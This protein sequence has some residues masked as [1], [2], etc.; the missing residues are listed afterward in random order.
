MTSLTSYKPR[1]SRH[2]ETPRIVIAPTP[3]TQAIYNQIREDEA[4]HS[5]QHSLHPQDDPADLLRPRDRRA[6]S[7]SRSPTTESHISGSLSP[8]SITDQPE[9]N[10]AQGA[11]ASPTA[12]RRPRGRRA[13]PLKLDKR[14]KTA[15]KR[16]LGFVCLQCKQKKVAVCA[17]SSR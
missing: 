3:Q 5:Q 4:R 12:V 14:F 10:L 13:G 6:P 1:K 2:Q 11:E 9:N 8:A 7:M 17:V 15:I 16:K